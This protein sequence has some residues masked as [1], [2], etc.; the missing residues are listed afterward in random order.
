MTAHQTAD[1]AVELSEQE[2]QQHCLHSGN[3]GGPEGVVAYRW[4]QHHG[5]NFQPYGYATAFATHISTGPRDRQEELYSEPYVKGLKA[6]IEALRAE[7]TGAQGVLGIG[8][9]DAEV[10]AAYERQNV[11]LM[12][13]L[14]S[15]K[16]LRRALEA[17]ATSRA[18]APAQAEPF[19]TAEII[20]L[21]ESFVHAQAEQPADST[22]KLH[23]GDS[24]FE[25]WY[26]TYPRQGI[27]KQVARDAYAAGMGDPLVTY[28]QPVQPAMQASSRKRFD[29]WLDDVTKNQGSS[30]PTPWQTWQAAINTISQPVQPAP[31][32]VAVGAQDA[33]DT[34]N[35]TLNRIGDLAHD[36]SKGPAIHDDLWEIRRMAYEGQIE[37]D[38][39]PPGSASGSVVARGAEPL[40]CQIHA[41]VKRGEAT[42]DHGLIGNL[43]CI[44]DLSLIHI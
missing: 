2:K 27:S 12:A 30:M 3:A 15:R 28:A 44:L 18:T 29:Y 35:A 25:E 5:K 8:V 1:G 21:N 33:I 16:A 38:A 20:I 34:L 24:S 7:L 10:D 37:F 11:A 26:Q 22:P 41:L 6:E 39:T 13:G 42:D 14:T 23:V 9:S 4:A 40:V 17:F 31:V 43:H 19:T 36:R 32:P